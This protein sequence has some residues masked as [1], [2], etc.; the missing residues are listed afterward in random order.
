[1]ELRRSRFI[2]MGSKI[3]AGLIVGAVLAVVPVSPSSATHLTSVTLSSASA[4]QGT[5]SVALSGLVDNNTDSPP[6]CWYGWKLSSS[7]GTLSGAV[8]QAPPGVHLVSPYTLTV[9]TAALAPGVYGVSVTSTWVAPAGCANDGPKTANATITITGRTGAFQCR[10][11]AARTQTDY[12]PANPAYNPCKDDNNYFAQVQPLAGLGQ[13]GAVRA[14]TDQQP[15]VLN[16]APPNAADYADA[17]GHVAGV[18]IL[19]GGVRIKTGAIWVQSSVNCQGIGMTPHRN[20][21]GTVATLSVN[22]RGTATTNEYLKIVVGS[23]TIELNKVT[24]SGNAATRQGLVITKTPLIGAPL[25][26]VI[27]EATAGW[28]GNPCKA[29]L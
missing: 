2:R 13:L 22:G 14:T 26:I 5:A 8:V 12:Q 10:A 18:N 4:P 7:N 28:T 29:V 15:D 6:Q 3:G 1:M 27:A 19:V 9:N 16:S 21:N 11:F 20:T 23:V 25:K 17:Q 24:V